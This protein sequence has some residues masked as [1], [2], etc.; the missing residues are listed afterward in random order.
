MEKCKFGCGQDGI[1]KRVDGSVCCSKHYSSCPEMRKINISKREDVKI[2][3]SQKLHG[4]YVSDETKEKLRQ[5]RL[6]KKLSEEHKRKIS[7]ANKGKKLTKNALEKRRELNIL[8]GK[9][10]RL[11]IEYIKEKYPLFSKIEEMR[12]DPYNLGENIIQVHCK[13]HNCNNS[14]EKGGWFIPTYSQI[15]ERIRNLEQRG[16]DLSYF[17]CS[18]KCKGECPLYQSR[19]KLYKST[20][21]YTEYDLRILNEFVLNRD[22]YICQFCGK[23]AEHVHH[24]RPQKLEPFFALDPDY[25]WS[26]CEK[27]H[28]EKGHRKNSNCNTG[29]LSTILCI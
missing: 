6:G 2:K 4:H 22:N 1:Y 25:A 9:K 14:K 18:E 8:L 24:E 21:S 15:Y 23:P 19:G 12:Y 29:K 16:E 20:N 13:N 3:K 26:C 5:S 28:Y 27:C 10:L 11:N 17:Y 7:E